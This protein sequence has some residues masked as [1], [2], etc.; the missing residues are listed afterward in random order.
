MARHNKILE[1]KTD[2]PHCGHKWNYKLLQIL[3]HEQQKESINMKCYCENRNIIRENINGFL[4]MRK[5][6]MKKHQV[7]RVKK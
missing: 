2:C 7:K 3:M 5:Y 6:I 4:V 1:H